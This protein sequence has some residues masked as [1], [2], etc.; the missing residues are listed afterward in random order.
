MI[1]LV[2]GIVDEAHIPVRAFHTALAADRF[3]LACAGHHSAYPRPLGRQNGTVEAVRE[4]ETAREQWRDLHP[5]GPTHE[6]DGEFYVT[7]VP[8][9]TI[10]SNATDLAATFKQRDELTDRIVAMVGRTFEPGKLLHVEIGRSLVSGPVV[11]TSGET[12]YIRNP[13]TDAV[14]AVEARKVLEQRGLV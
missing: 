1:Y 2:T 4:L 10:K 14:R 13:R 12:V 7:P 11:R 8:V 9:D 6:W 5:A 3:A